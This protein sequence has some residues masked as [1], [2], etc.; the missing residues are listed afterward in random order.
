M[1]E[2]AY[3][4]PTRG[5]RWVLSIGHGSPR[6][7][8]SDIASLICEDIEDGQVVYARHL[9]HCGRR[10]NKPLHPRGVASAEPRSGESDGST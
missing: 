2:I 8:Q 5:K 9:W 4:S 1:I 6:Y 10:P 7:G 3:Y